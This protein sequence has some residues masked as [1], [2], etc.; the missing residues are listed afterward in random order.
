MPNIVNMNGV[1]CPEWL[2]PV[3]HQAQNDGV[4]IPAWMFPG[5][6]GSGFLEEWWN[7][8]YVPSRVKVQIGANVYN[9]NCGIH[10]AKYLEMD[11]G[12][13]VS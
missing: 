10:I 9:D 6:P 7:L 8:A 1:P 11:R 13:L 2:P 3:I 4:A 12:K 5:M